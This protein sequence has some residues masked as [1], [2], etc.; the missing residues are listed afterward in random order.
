V[1]GGHERDSRAQACVGEMG[2]GHGVGA[3]HTIWASNI[4]ASVDG[5]EQGWRSRRWKVSGATARR[6]RI[7]PAERAPLCVVD[8][9]TT[10][11]I[12]VEIIVIIVNPNDEFMSGCN[13]YSFN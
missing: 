10:R 1:R 8:A 11:L 3:C 5:G 6:W 2:R 7:R 9:Y 12:V 4:R 13:K